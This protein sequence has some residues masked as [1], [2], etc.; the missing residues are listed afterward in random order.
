MILTCT[1]MPI[2]S[3][4]ATLLAVKYLT[5]FTL[6]EQMTLLAHKSKDLLLQEPE[7][8]ETHNILMPAIVLHL[9]HLF[10][11]FVIS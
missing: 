3:T 5:V 4:P 9:Y 2:L 1:K 7:R 10:F 6:F 11:R 8:R